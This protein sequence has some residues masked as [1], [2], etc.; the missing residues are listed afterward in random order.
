MT[1]WPAFEDSEECPFLVPVVAD[2]LWLHPLGVY[3]RRPGHPVRVPASSTLARV[4]STVAHER[5]EGYWTSTGDPG[6]AFVPRAP[7]N[8]SVARARWRGAP[9]RD[10]RSAQA[11]RPFGYWEIT[12]ACPRVSPWPRR[13]GGPGS[14]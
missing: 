6:G 8:G 13:I 9:S 11:D 5:C 14:G 12:R 3:C 4:C 10:G 7:V 1:P 2:R